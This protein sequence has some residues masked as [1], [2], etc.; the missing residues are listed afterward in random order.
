MLFLRKFYVSLMSF[1]YRFKIKPRRGRCEMFLVLKVDV[2]LC[3]SGDVHFFGH[4]KKD[5]CVLGRNNLC[6]CCKR[7]SG[8]DY[9]RCEKTYVQRVTCQ[10]NGD[11]KNENLSVQGRQLGLGYIHGDALICIKYQVTV[12]PLVSF[13]GLYNFGCLVYP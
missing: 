11:N 13:F 7:S 2:K 6:M 8:L 1:T 5:Q 12:E 9:C 4:L 3:P 10:L